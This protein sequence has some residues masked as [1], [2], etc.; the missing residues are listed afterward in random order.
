V[1]GE[2]IVV[3]DVPSVFAEQVVDAFHGRVDEEFSL[4]VSG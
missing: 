3:D 2:L 1:H 4:A